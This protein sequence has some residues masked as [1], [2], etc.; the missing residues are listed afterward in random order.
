[1]SLSLGRILKEFKLRI[2][3]E[4]G[5]GKAFLVKAFARGDDLPHIDVGAARGIGVVFAFPDPMRRAW[6]AAGVRIDDP[7][8]AEMAFRY[9]QAFWDDLRGF[10]IFDR[11]DLKEEA[12]EA[13]RCALRGER[14]EKIQ[15]LDGR[16]GPLS[17]GG[18]CGGKQHEDPH[19]GDREVVELRKA[20]GSILIRSAF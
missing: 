4:E 16:G 3:A 11:G 7:Q 14:E 20:A 15:I 1:M 5:K 9:F 19:P 2:L 8:I 6:N 17:D 10:L 18:R 12:V 13:L